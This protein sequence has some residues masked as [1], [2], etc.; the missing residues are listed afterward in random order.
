MHITLYVMAL[1][2]GLGLTIQVG[3]NAA[4]RG[5]TGSAGFASL[6]NFLVGTLALAV[7]L[8]ATRQGLPSREAL[9]AVPWW[10]W[11]GGMLGAFYVASSTVVGPAL[12]GTML[13]ALTV[14]GQLSAALLVDHFGWL[15]FPEH[16]ITLT[17]IAGVAL[18]LAGVWLIAR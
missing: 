11:F 7:F 9:S 3:L 16:P 5:Q 14:L 18:L 8:L 17:R 15:G 1:I 13:L 10:G 2:A 12:G 6:A 4:I